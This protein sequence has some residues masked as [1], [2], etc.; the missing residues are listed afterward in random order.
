MNTTINTKRKWL[1]AALA[2][3]LVIALSFTLVACGTSTAS[4]NKGQSEIGNSGTSMRVALAASPMSLATTASGTITVS[5]TITATVL[6][7]DAPDKSVDWTIEWCVP[8]E[9]EEVT[10]YLTVTPESDGALTATITAYRAFEGASA[11]VKA[12]T[13]VGG[14]TATC[15]VAYEGAP[16]SLSF[17]LDGT[18]YGSTDTVD[19][20]AGSTNNFT[21]NLK[22]TLGVVGSKY[23]TFEIVKIQGQGRFTMLKEYVVNGS[24]RSSEDIVFNL[25]AGTYSY[26]DEV[27]GDPLTLTIGPDAFFDVSIDGDTMIVNAKRSESSYINGYP[28]TGY[29]FSY[30]GTYTDPR[31]G[32]IP[33]DCR[34]YILVR[35]TVSG[36]EA[37]IYVDIESTVNSISLNNTYLAF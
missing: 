33:D 2:V 34:W 19:V 3:M 7:V 36:E 37:L 6:P 13:R 10:D 20:V 29:R 11:Y 12:T 31:S 24:V 14:Y 4:D 15:L 16:E 18:E 35:D 28:R 30:K 32:G 8:I 21:L 5:K 26:T 1:V 22:N 23:G 17:V 27:S 9:G 25:E